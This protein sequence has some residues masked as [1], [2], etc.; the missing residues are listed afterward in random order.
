MTTGLSRRYYRVQI[1]I[2]MR[3][4]NNNEWLRYTESDSAIVFIHGLMSNSTSCWLF[5]SEKD[6]KHQS[7]WPD[8]VA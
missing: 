2:S 3:P 7:Y 1:P 4:I 5:E 8:L 6:P